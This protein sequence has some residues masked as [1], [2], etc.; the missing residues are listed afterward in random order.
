MLAKNATPGCI[1]RLAQVTQSIS[2]CNLLQP[3]IHGLV[4]E[5]RQCAH[6]IYRVVV[7]LSKL[8]R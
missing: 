5:V 1:N 8:L 7:E 2:L 4:E 3:M 6:K